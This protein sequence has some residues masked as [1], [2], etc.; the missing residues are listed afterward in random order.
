[1][2]SSIEAN[3]P[4]FI[5]FQPPSGGFSFLDI[6][7]SNTIAV[8]PISTAEDLRFQLKFDGLNLSGRTL[9]IEVRE[10]SSNAL[11]ATLT[12][13]AG[14]ILAGTND[15]TALY[16][17][18]SMAGWAR[19][20]YQAD[21][22][23]KT[24]G[25]ALRLMA[26]RIIYDEPGNLVYGV[27][28]NQATVR[29][30]G[31]QA[32]V[33]AIGG[34]GPAGP[35]NS[36]AVGTV[37]TGA[38][39]APAAASITGAAPSQ[40]LNLTIPRGDTGATGDAATVAA[41]TTTT[42]AAGSNASVTNSG[43]SAAAVFNF[44]I[45]RGDTGAT[46]PA[47]TLTI[48]T[49]TTSPPA[50]SASATI[51]GTAPNQTLNLT[52]PRGDQGPAGSVVD[53]DKGDITV[54]SGGT[55][56]TVDNNAVDDAKLRDSAALSVIGR[57]ANSSGDPADITAGTDGHVL[58]RSGASVGFGDVATAGIADKAVTLAKQAD[59]A[60]SV[61]MGRA[62]AGPGSQEAMTGAQALG[63][64]TS[65]AGAVSG[66][67]NLLVNASF[68]VNQRAHA[69]GALT[70]GNFGYDRWKADTGGATYSVSGRAMT[71][72]AGTV[73][74]V[75]DGADILVSGT[76]VINW[77]GTATCAIDGVAKTKGATFTLTAGTNCTVKFTGGT[78]SYPQIEPGSTPTSFEARP[79]SLE[80]LL[81]RRF[82]Q[83]VQWQLS[84]V[85]TAANQ[86]IY[87]TVNF[88][89]MRA[90]PTAALAGG[91]F[92]NCGLVNSPSVTASF[93]VD[94]ARSAAAGPI[95]AGYAVFISADL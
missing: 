14:L 47:N 34:V 40:T 41:G 26:V 83:L 87:G 32:V 68:L 18:A 4:Q 64:I 48:G 70:S 20:E 90:V 55:A 24:S 49:V 10:R 31:N 33:T 63:I 80:F 74:Q 19:S 84:T 13:G 12:I 16:P 75:I 76:Y 51:T 17:K 81:C 38:A 43:T 93:I 71:I 57:S 35:A 85:A 65:S 67:R 60:T 5:P 78:V 46:G 56:W 44:D 29:W 54:S 28:G 61:L 37:T 25:Q 69:G 72:S 2:S 1:M 27:R 89:P 21:L 23:D 62:T 6:S 9:E 39:G 66:V 58:R 22:V 45:P 30:G 11:K 50:G 77:T 7:M 73:V 94:F 15:L 92:S 42:G 79:A 88:Q 3:L 53:G 86:D 91:T 82:C 8:F 95:Y 36:L 52:L 59:V